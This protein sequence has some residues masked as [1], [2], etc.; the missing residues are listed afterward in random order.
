MKFSQRYGYTPVREIIQFESIDDP[1]RNKLWNLLDFYVWSDTNPYEEYT[2]DLLELCKSLMFGYFNKPVD[3]IDNVWRRERTKI[4]QYFFKCEWYEVYDFIEYI[5]DKYTDYKIKNF[6]RDCNFVLTTE[7]SAYRIVDKRFSPITNNEEIK[8][9]EEVIVSSKDSV[10]MHMRRA[11]ELLSNRNSPDYRNS[12]K[13]SISAVESLAAD[14]MGKKGTLGQLLKELEQ[15]IG[16]HPALRDAF[17]KLYGYTTDSN[18]IRHAIFDSDN[19]SFDDA[20][21]FLVACSAFINYIK[22]KIK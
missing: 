12:I 11:L 18:G 22:I 14:I 3:E 9:I 19:L 4:K 1:L 8:E 15:K 7:M 17:N 6:I 20:K 13:E 10:T 21:F 5:L 2:Q 16:L